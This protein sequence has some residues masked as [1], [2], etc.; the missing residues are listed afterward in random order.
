MR[1][2]W[3]GQAG[4]LLEHENACILIDPYLSDL[5]GQK[6]PARRRRIPIAEEYFESFPRYASCYHMM[7]KLKS[8]T[9]IRRPKVPMTTIIGTFAF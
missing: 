5:I 3:L 2:T 6:D 1:F 8:T 7:I 4:I 9:T